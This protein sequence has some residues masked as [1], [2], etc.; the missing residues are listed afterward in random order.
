VGTGSKSVVGA[1]V[2]GW[3]VLLGVVLQLSGGAAPGNAAL[4]GKNGRIAF[5]EIIGDDTTNAELQTIRPNGKGLR[6]ISSQGF[7]PGVLTPGAAT[8][9]QRLV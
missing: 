3:A 5:T 9:L 4:P 7:F 8:G 2:A 1:R 6:S